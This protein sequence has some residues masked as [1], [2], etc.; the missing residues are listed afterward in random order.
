MM[1]SASHGRKEP[2][3]EVVTKQKSRAAEHDVQPLAHLCDLA[4]DHATGLPKS[5]A[6]VAEDLDTGFETGEARMERAKMA[7][8]LVREHT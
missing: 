4:P 5:V 7:L 6:Q 2:V 1:D 3:A 8:N